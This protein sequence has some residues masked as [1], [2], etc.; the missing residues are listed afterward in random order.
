[1]SLLE[2]I[3]ETAKGLPEPVQEEAMRYVEYL[4]LRAE[5]SRE[6]AEWTRLSAEN[7]SAAYGPDDAIY[8]DEEPSVS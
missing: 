1:M 2:R 8:D 7:L 4:R 6:E 5:T 3:Y